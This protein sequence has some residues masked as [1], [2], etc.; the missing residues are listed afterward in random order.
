M[1]RIKF[2]NLYSLY[3]FLIIYSVHSYMEVPHLIHTD[4]IIYIHN[5][6]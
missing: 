2:N 1:L 3:N 6:L 4:F 5:L